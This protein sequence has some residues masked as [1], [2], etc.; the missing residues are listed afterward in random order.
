MNKLLGQDEEYILSVDFVRIAGQQKK[1]ETLRFQ[2][3]ISSRTEYLSS[4]HSAVL[5][6]TYPSFPMFPLV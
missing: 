1:D 3:V 4:P 2:D 5:Q 6:L